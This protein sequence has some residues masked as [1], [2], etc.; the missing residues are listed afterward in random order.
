MKIREQF[1]RASL[2]EEP[3]VTNLFN[4]G[5]QIFLKPVD[6]WIELISRST[7]CQTTNQVVL[8]SGL[9][10]SNKSGYE[11]W[12]ISVGSKGE[13]PI[14]VIVVL[15]KP[16]TNNSGTRIGCPTRSIVVDDINFGAKF[17]KM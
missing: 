6:D 17:G 9:A 8:N 15:G 14:V 10:E 7:N 12:V 2:V 13:C 11:L 1:P 4:A 5:G 3:D 16:G